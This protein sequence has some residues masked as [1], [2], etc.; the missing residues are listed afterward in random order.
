MD[1]VDDLDVRLHHRALMDSAGLPR[2][3]A[4]CRELGV[5]AM[6]KQLNE[7]ETML[8]EDE[9][10]LRER[11]DTIVLASFSNPEHLW[12]ALCARTEGSRAKDYFLSIM[13]HLLLL[14]EEG[15]Q[16]AYH[17]RLLDSLV[18]D[19]VM[20]GK[21]ATAEHRLGHSVQRLIAQMNEV[22]RSQAAEDEA[23]EARA[24]ALRLKLE[25]EVLEE[26]I[27]QGLD[28]LVGQLKDKISHLEQK[29]AI[30]R[31]TT[32]RLQ[33]QL[34]AQK[35]GYEEQIA[36]LEAQIMELFRMLRELGKGM[37][38]II[39]SNS[40]SMDRKTLIEV[41]NKHLERAK[42]ISILE[43]RGR[44]KK[45]GAGGGEGEDESEGSEE[46]SM[47]VT[48]RKTDGRK[49]GNSVRGKHNVMTKSARVSAAQVGRDSQF[50]DADEADVREQIQ[51][52]LAAG[53]KIVSPCTGVSVSVLMM[54]AAL[55]GRWTHG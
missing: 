22:D 26:E 37:D 32:S 28:G 24:Q 2:I 29:L 27:S 20:D 39:E 50:M 9:Q 11:Q 30:A 33:N 51:Q 55:S 5:S 43:G 48:P 52:Q 6:G 34:E 15:P 14:R 46:E 18:S 12:N 45:K 53:V 1:V 54:L 17:Y 25:K 4:L 21:L 44:K 23:A 41:L 16:L 10:R 8:E 7:L 3:L 35:A 42:T 36:Q 40:G 13:R 47:D 31:E 19:I 38:T 49:G